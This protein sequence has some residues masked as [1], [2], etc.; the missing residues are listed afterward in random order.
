MEETKKC[1]CC[2]RELPISMFTKGGYGIHNTCKECAVKK[3]QATKEKKDKE[4]NYEN[5]I[6][7]AKKMRLLDFTPRDLMEELK[8]RGYRGKILVPVTT[9]KEVDFE[10]EF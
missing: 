2:G 5:E 3:R 7:Q 6:E 9:Y 1:K 4:R 8:R 10:D